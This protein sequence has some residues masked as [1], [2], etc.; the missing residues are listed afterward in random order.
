MKKKLA[1]LL[2]LLLALCLLA[3]CGGNADSATT[4]SSTQTTAAITTAAGTEAPEQPANPTEITLPVTVEGAVFGGAA[5]DKIAIDLHFDPAWITE[6]SNTEYNN[7]LAAFASVLCADIYYREKDAAKSSANRVLTESSADAYTQMALLEALGYTDVQFIETYKQ[8]TYSADTNDSGTVLLAYRNV[9]NKYDSYI[10]VLRGCFSIGERLSAYD[11][12][13][14]DASYA[15]LTGAH[16]EWENQDRFKGVDVAVNRIKTFFV[17]YR[18]KHSSD[19]RE[20]TVLVT[21]H[22]RG[23][24]LAE[25]LGE[26]LER[27]GTVKSYT[28]TF[29]AMPV[30]AEES[31]ASCHTVFNILDSNDY[32]TNPLPF[33][34][35]TMY[36]YG[37]D[38]AVNLAKD[39]ALQQKIA[40]V[41]GRSDYACLDTEKMAEYVSL[42]GQ[43]FPDRASLYNTV[44]SAATVYDTFEAASSAVANLKLYIDGMAVS[45]FYTVSEPAEKD[46][47]YTVT[48]AYEGAAIVNSFAQIQAYGK[49]GYDGF[50]LLFA[51]DTD[52]CRMADI[53]Y[54]NAAAINAGHLLVNGYVLALNAP[55]KN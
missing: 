46:G 41:K 25:T 35:E 54:E 22:S 44:T 39:T 1:T 37:T 5:T 31:A 6:G 30:T 14:S 17:D 9:D 4:T 3:S 52:A 28:Y 12:G 23:A 34:T 29:N 13:S 16:T 24:M 40:E 43:R 19:D 49:S 50:N 53:L 51:G 33:G 7:K 18:A 2:T 42:F 38:I 55:I 20:A 21:G 27:E 48:V 47:K 8:G 15:A 45:S 26:N 11:V 32:Y 10:L 36:R